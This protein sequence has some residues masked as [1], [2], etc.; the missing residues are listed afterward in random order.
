[1]PRLEPSHLFIHKDVNHR[2]FCHSRESGNPGRNWIPGQARNDEQ[3]GTYVLVYKKA[4]SY[5]AFSTFSLK[6]LPVPPDLLG[7]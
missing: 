4:L 7:G 5:P 2:T 1:M 3:G 6:A